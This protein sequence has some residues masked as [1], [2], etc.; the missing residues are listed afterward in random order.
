[1]TIRAYHNPAGSRIVQWDFGL[2]APPDFALPRIGM[3]SELSPGL[4][5]GPLTI[6]TAVSVS[7]F[8]G[9]RGNALA[10]DARVWNIW[11][12]NQ[13]MCEAWSGP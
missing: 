5:S 8:A 7:V 13:E 2:I 6:M 10:V 4:L 12:C 9:W 1:M 11:R 3:F